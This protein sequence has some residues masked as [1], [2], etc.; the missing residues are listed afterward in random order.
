MSGG[1]SRNGA[2]PVASSGA[3]LAS[4]DATMNR[5]AVIHRRGL[6]REAVR[7]SLSLPGLFPPAR[8]AES[9]HIDGGVLDNLP[10]RSL[11]ED[12]GPILAVNIAAAGGLSTRS[13]PPP[14]AQPP[15]DAACARR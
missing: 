7:A 12:E 15:R 11:D 6:V 4:L 1:V 9:L 3:L 5:T 2:L 8:L 10:V 14:D 13:G